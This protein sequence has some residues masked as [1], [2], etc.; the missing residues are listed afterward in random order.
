MEDPLPPR[1]PGSPAPLHGP[2][3]LFVATF[4]EEGTR[5]EDLAAAPFGLS[6]AGGR[7]GLGQRA[8][9]RPRSFHRRVGL[10]AS[11]HST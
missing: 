3:R 1:P 11:P 10:I 9:E 8:E 5:I 6:L 2:Q 4:R 7:L